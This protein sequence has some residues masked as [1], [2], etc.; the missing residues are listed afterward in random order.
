MDQNFLAQVIASNPHM[1]NGFFIKDNA[2]RFNKLE[3]LIS[4]N[5]KMEDVR[6]YFNDHI[7]DKIDWQSPP[8]VSLP[9]LYKSRAQQ[10]RNSYDKIIL[11][12]SGGA[13]STN[14]L[15]SFID[16]GIKPDKVWSFGAW[17]HSIDKY[18]D[19]TNLEISK[20]A[21]PYLEKTK[22]MGID[23]EYINLIDVDYTYQE[24]WILDAPSTRLA[25]DT[26]I[27]KHLLF[28]NPEIQKWV[29]QGKKVAFVFGHDKPRVMIDNG[30]WVC[31]FIDSVL[32]H[33][34]TSQIEH[35]DGPFTE[36]FYWTPDMPSLV[37][38]AAHATINSFEL[39][40]SRK[41]LLS[42]FMNSADF[43][44]ET[45]N[46][47]VSKSIYPGTWDPDDNFSLGKSKGRFNQF[48]CH[49]AAFLFDRGGHWKDFK[50]WKQG[51]VDVHR[52]VHSSVLVPDKQ[53]NS[54]WSK[55]Y[56]IRPIKQ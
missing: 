4:S 28:E 14:V 44:M 29:D 53:I 51:L 22:K 23:V 15:L 42:F 8:N 26:Q 54:H 49:K 37:H 20:S 18:N 33:R 56:K 50:A 32:G 41:K 1:K 5:T 39:K 21:W 2:I 19:Y 3:F 47:I 10:L 43:D 52:Q 36:Y 35:T 7:Y 16:N 45:Y 6:F 31:G 17:S 25:A 13:D 38:A 48:F 9:Y 12:F 11:M 46:Y 34:W 40:M 30:W 27:R 55:F 24:S